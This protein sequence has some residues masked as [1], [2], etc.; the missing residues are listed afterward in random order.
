MTNLDEKPECPLC[1]PNAEINLKELERYLI[2]A[3]LRRTNGHV[4][5][6][7]KLLGVGKTTLYRKM[8]CLAL[9]ADNLSNTHQENPHVCPGGG[10]MLAL[11]EDDGGLSPSR[12]PAQ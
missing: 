12:V 4:I 5:S 6:A 10:I 8:K 7:A 2:A 3:A 1:G 11:A 9:H